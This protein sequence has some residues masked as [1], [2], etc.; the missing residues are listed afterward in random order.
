LPAGQVDLQAVDACLGGVIS[1]PEQLFGHSWVDFHHTA[2][3]VS[4]NFNA[5]D[6][7]RGWKEE[8]LPP[9]GTAG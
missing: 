2:S 9:V 5:L 4:I 8:D 6:A 7:L 1:L 3:G